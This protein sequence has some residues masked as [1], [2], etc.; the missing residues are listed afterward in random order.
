MTLAL[1]GR[2]KNGFSSGVQAVYPSAET[3]AATALSLSCY[4]AFGHL[5]MAGK[6]FTSSKPFRFS[7]A[8]KALDPLIVLQS[9]L[10]GDP[11]A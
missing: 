6:G 10:G 8:F 3:S 5:V 2:L 4:Q 7:S 9:L 1:T 11:N